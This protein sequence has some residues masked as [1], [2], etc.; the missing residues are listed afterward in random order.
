MNIR[1]QEK[2]IVYAS[3]CLRAAHEWEQTC[4]YIHINPW[5]KHLP[6]ALIISLLLDW[7][8]VV[9][10]QPKHLPP[11][12]LSAQMPSSSLQST[13]SMLSKP[14]QVQLRR[15]RSST[16][17]NPSLPP[18]DTSWAK[19]ACS[20]SSKCRGNENNNWHW[21]PPT[22][23]SLLAVFQ[24]YSE[25]SEEDAHSMLEEQIK[26]SVKTGATKVVLRHQKNWHQPWKRHT[27]LGRTAPSRD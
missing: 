17:S 12:P 18:T 24:G 4:T 27:I 26:Q 7:V 5:P 8:P 21:S 19:S 15:L 9:A 23:L 3:V 13:P 11:C 22:V 6:C 20:S 16:N 10:A 25:E 2:Y 14:V 1:C